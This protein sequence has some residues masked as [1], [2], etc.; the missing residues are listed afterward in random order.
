MGLKESDVAKMEDK[1]DIKGLV[2]ALKSKEDGAIRKKAAIALGNV[3]SM[4]AVDALVEA[5]EDQ[6]Y[7]VSDEAVKALIDIG[8]PSV[9]PLIRALGNKK[10][11]V[12]QGA[13]KAL[14]KIGNTR[15]S[16]M[17][18][19]TVRAHP[20]MHE[21]EVLTRAGDEL[22]IFA[23]K[24]GQ[25]RVRQNAVDALDRL[26]W[27]PTT[28]TEKACYLLV[29]K[30]WEELVKMGDKAAEILDAALMDGC[31]HFREEA[32]SA[33]RSMGDPAATD[34]IGPVLGIDATALQVEEAEAVPEAPPVAPE[35]PS[36]P[37]VVEEK[38][39]QI[40]E[41]E[42]V[43]KETTVVQ[44]PAQ[45]GPVVRE[46]LLEEEAADPT[47]QTEEGPEVAILEQMAREK[48]VAAAEAKP[49]DGAVGA[50][51][52]D[53]ASEDTGTREKAVEAL[54]RLGWEP[55]NDAQ[56]AQFLLA[57]R[58]WQQLA[59]MGQPVLD[60]LIEALKEGDKE[61][62]AGVIWTL[63]AIRGIT[64]VKALGQAMNAE[65]GWLRRSV[66]LALGETRSRWAV[67]HLLQALSDEDG[68]VRRDAAHALAKIGKD[69]VDPIL[70]EAKDRPPHIHQDAIAAL[71][72][73]G[74]PGVESLLRALKSEDRILQLTAAEA[75]DRQGWKPSNQAE[76]VDYLIVKRKW[77]ALAELGAPAVQALVEG[78]QD[79]DEHV[80]SGAVWTLARIEDERGVEPILQSLKDEDSWVRR[81]AAEALGKLK[82][83]RAAQSLIEALGDEDEWVRIEVIGSLVGIGE[84]AM[85][86]LVKAVRDDN[87]R[88]RSGAAEVLRQIARGSHTSGPEG[89]P[90]S[91][92]CR[93][94]GPSGGIGSKRNRTPDPSPQ[95][96]RHRC[97]GEG[98][99]DHRKDRRAGSGAP[100]QGLEGRR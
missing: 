42:A 28:D 9:E 8:Q 97:P 92:S 58:R 44:E 47:M 88:V 76:N 71:A 34:L 90:R 32:V 45:G 60:A 37:P 81:D 43:S 51:L 24:A 16:D 73:I 6:D 80:R 33:L 66:I 75:L 65:S 89:S 62:R 67:D 57:G 2:K 95:G 87:S 49:I 13:G 12:W 96:R 19:E 52:K 79:K 27:Q 20:K 86:L 93:R 29:G 56:R 78:L 11:Q 7:E 91:H 26:G 61:T 82:D 38:T 59:D 18:I 55:A 83:P 23:L 54:E 30:R 69:A 94:V 21:R 41:V 72:L 17:M 84:P 46:T 85:G 5:L 14:E 53:L 3:G 63:G 98:S 100:D 40:E 31:E 35:P 64:A 77:E 68:L 48:E 10:D 99:P 74:K 15:A 36:P 70:Q 4:R 39:I 50:L 1:R 22:L 25:S